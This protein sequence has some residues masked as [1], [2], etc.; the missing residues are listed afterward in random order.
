M[1]LIEEA[2]GGNVKIHLQPIEENTSSSF[3]AV[4]WTNYNDYEI[5]FKIL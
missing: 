5:I 1:T 3:T 4:I 2:D